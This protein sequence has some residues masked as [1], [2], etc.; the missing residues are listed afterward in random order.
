NEA[1]RSDEIFI[2][3]DGVRIENSIG[4]H[5]Q[6][7]GRNFSI[8]VSASRFV[9]ETTDYQ[10]FEDFTNK[11]REILAILHEVLGVMGVQG[12][13]LRYVNLVQPRA[14]ETFRTYLH[15][16]LSGLDD[17]F[18]ERSESM[19]SAAFVGKTD[20]GQLSIRIHEAPLPTDGA[21]LMRLQVPADLATNMMIDGD[22]L[23]IP[24]LRYRL[25]DLDHRSAVISEDFAVPR[26]LTALERLPETIGRAFESSLK[27]GAYAKWSASMRE[28]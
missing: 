1:S 24:G 18:L 26:I 2:S 7:S 15:D 11:V 10:G 23:F 13:G 27:A 8:R 14:G 22:N 5:F 20:E 25:L 19:F 17:D 28:G 16:R 4:W 3:P 9:I 12:I 21:E 6:N